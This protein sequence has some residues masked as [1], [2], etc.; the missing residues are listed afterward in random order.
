MLKIRLKKQLH[1]HFGDMLLDVSIEVERGTFVSLYGKSGAG[2]T[3]ILRMLAGLMQPESGYIEVGGEVWLD[4]QKG[5]ALKP[6]RRNLGFVFQDYAL[7]PNMSV[8]ENLLFALARGQNKKAV[9]ELINMVELRELQGRYPHELSGGQKQRVALARALVRRPPL[10]LLDEPLSA[11]DFDMRSKLQEYIL[12]LHRKYH[13]TT[14]L[15]SHD[16]PE[17]V[18]MADVVYRIDEG[19][20]TTGGTPRELLGKQL[21]RYLASLTCRHKNPGQR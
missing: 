20:I 9:E 10:L 21:E 4:T 12:H 8:R 16:L 6:Q 18:R 3:S 13:L 5:V 19:K 15:V 14:L 17:V 11:L 1:A 2:K 7:F